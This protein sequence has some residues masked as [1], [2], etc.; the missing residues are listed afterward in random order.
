M[1]LGVRRCG[2]GGGF[3]RDNTLG[4]IFT[5]DSTDYDD[6]VLFAIK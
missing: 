1:H 3:I 2:G 6:L 5:V 4:H